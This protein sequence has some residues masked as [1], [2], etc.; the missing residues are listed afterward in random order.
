MCSRSSTTRQP[1]SELPDRYADAAAV[2]AEEDVATVPTASATE[3]AR[4]V[5]AGTLL[6]E[7]VVLALPRLAQENASKTRFTPP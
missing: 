2:L 3:A 6:L 1:R 4:Y 7:T 5:V